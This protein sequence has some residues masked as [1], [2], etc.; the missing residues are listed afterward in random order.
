LPSKVILYI[1]HAL[2]LFSNK[3]IRKKANKIR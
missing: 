1:L 3:V 2:I